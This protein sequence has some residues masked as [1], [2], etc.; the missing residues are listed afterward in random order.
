L[1]GAHLALQLPHAL[2]VADAGDLEATDPAVVP[3]TLVELAAVD[4]GE[5]RHPVVTR[6]VAEVRGMGGGA[7]IGR[8]R[9][10]VDANQVLPAALDQVM[11]DRGTDDPSLADDD[12]SRLL[13]QPPLAGALT[14]HPG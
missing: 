6:H 5:D 13:W 2:V 11:R 14:V 4:G 7:D 10:F 9:R 8:N 3:E 12:R 1:G